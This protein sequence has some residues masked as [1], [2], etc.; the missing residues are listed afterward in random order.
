MDVVRKRRELH[1]NSVLYFLRRCGDGRSAALPFKPKNPTDTNFLWLIM[2]AAAALN[3]KAIAPDD[4][5]EE[6][7]KLSRRIM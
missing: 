2:A 6:E 5:E 7:K 4:E 3:A 1:E